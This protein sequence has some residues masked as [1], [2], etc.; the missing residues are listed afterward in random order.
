MKNK[1]Q[2]IKF[3]N[4]AEK[5]SLVVLD[6]LKVRDFQEFKFGQRVIYTTLSKLVDYGFIN[7]KDINE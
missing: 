1:T 2:Y 5:I 4:N 7:A 6:E 3:T